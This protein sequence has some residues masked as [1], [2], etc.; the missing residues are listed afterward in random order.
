MTADEI[1]SVQQMAQAGGINFVS[2]GSATEVANYFT[3]KQPQVAMFPKH[4]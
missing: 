2:V 4:V 3:L 1:M